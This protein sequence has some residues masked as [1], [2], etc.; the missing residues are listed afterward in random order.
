MAGVV[1]PWKVPSFERLLWRACRG[2]I[3]VDFREMED[4]LQHPDTVRARGKGEGIAEFLLWVSFQVFYHSSLLF[5]HLQGEMVQWTV[6]LISF[7]GDQIGQK[8]KKICDWWGF[9]FS[10][11]YFWDSETAPCCVLNLNFFGF[12]LLAASA[13]RHLH[14]PRALLRERRFS[15]DFKVE[16]K[17]S[18]QWVIFFWFLILHIHIKIIKRL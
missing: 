16:L 9:F 4:R 15:R 10:F 12:S 2:Y 17:I 5:L 14:T 7:W 1:H 18:N 8:V 3:I 6:F 13:L 11:F